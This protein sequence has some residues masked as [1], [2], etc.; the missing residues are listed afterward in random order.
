MG[1]FEIGL[2]NENI[3][4]KEESDDLPPA[5]DLNER[6]EDANDIGDKV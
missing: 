2:A 6:I 4:N 5:D 1:F 3:E